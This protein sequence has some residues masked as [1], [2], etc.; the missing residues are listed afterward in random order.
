M[1]AFQGSENPWEEKIAEFIF[2]FKPEIRTPICKMKRIVIKLYRYVFK[3][4]N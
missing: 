4:F 2:L 3:S 1:M